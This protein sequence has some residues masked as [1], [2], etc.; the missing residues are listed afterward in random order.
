MPRDANSAQSAWQIADEIAERLGS[1]PPSE[2][3]WLVRRVAWALH[4][5]RGSKSPRAD[6][7]DLSDDARGQL[8][9]EARAAIDAYEVH[10]P[11]EDL[12]AS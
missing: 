2:R 5:M 1:E 6:W 9:A 8:Y 12:G 7:L 4:V 3:Q 11:H 10:S